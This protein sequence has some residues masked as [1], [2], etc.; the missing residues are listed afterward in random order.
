MSSTN[1]VVADW[2]ANQTRGVLDYAY[3]IAIDDS[4]NV[5]VTG[6][7]YGSGTYND[8]ATLKY[9]ASGVQQWVAQYDG[10]GNSGDYAT[11]IAV[12]SSGNVY[13][14]G[15]TTFEDDGWHYTTIKYRQI[16]TGIVEESE[17]LSEFVLY[18]NYP[19]PFNPS[20][21]I[22]YQLPIQSHATIKVFDV[23]GREVATLVNGIE[24]PGYK[25]VTFDAG[26]LS[27]GIYYYRMQAGNY[28]ETKKSLLMK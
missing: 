26:M 14:T 28:V 13:V 25:T 6:Y 21:T 1:S 27:S 7:S 16:T 19:N 4:G 15:T 22:R 10:R 11:T 2:I 3:A 5:Y 17:V 12:D 9:D 18:Q 20:T 23:L 24:E 8:Y